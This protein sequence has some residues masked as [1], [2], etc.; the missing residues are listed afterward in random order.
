LGEIFSTASVEAVGVVVSFGVAVAVSLGA[1]VPSGVAVGVGESTVSVAAEVAVGVAVAVGV[2][3]DVAVGVFPPSFIPVTTAGAAIIEPIITTARA[4]AVSACVLSVIGVSGCLGWKS[5]ARYGVVA[6]ECSQVPEPD[7]HV[8]LRL[9]LVLDGLDESV[10]WGM[11]RRYLRD[12][13]DRAVANAVPVLRRV[14]F[15]ILG[16]DDPFETG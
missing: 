13:E 16:L 9:V 7:E 1:S 2:W 11:A 4:I 12:D 10:R 6:G 5:D 15:G 8:E 14:P 3:V